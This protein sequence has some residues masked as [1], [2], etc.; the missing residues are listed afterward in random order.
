MGNCQTK[1]ATSDAVAP[2]S[3]HQERKINTD[4]V[5]NTGSD[6]DPATPEKAESSKSIF[7]Q[8]PSQDAVV[9]LN[10]VVS[11]ASS[12][13]SSN[14]ANHVG[15]SAIES[16]TL[17][18]HSSTKSSSVLVPLAPSV[19]A[20]TVVSGK[21]AIANSYS[22]QYPKEGEKRDH[23]DDD[24][25]YDDDTRMFERQNEYNVESSID[26]T[27][28][29]FMDKLDAFRDSCCGGG[30]AASQSGTRQREM[31][32]REDDDDTEDKME[33]E[34]TQL[35]INRNQNVSPAESIEEDVSMIDAAAYPMPD[36]EESL[37][38]EPSSVSRGSSFF[39]RVRSKNKESTATV[40]ASVSRD[41][42]AVLSVASDDPNYKQKR[43]L[44]KKLRE[45]EALESKDPD[46]LTPEQREKV[47]S[48][49]SILQS[50]KELDD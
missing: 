2:A 47:E 6:T 27:S 44:N 48:K 1:K 34:K 12:R 15:G 25:D 39:S 11:K 32:E 4:V 43:K 35:R 41:S 30:A 7:T 9:Q 26:K 5:T 38:K 45:I 42:S 24:D 40:P 46:N 29:S 28:N 36:T 18:R 17:D 50:L 37:Q 21:S 3:G 16:G 23:D 14:A 8:S 33:D 49:A 22:Q 19:D 31:I 20:S 10:Q 13:D